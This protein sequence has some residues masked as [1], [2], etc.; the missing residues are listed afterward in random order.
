MPELVAGE[1]WKKLK[2][3]VETLIGSEKRRSRERKRMQAYHPSLMMSRRAHAVVEDWKPHP[4]DDLQS[5]RLVRVLDRL[6]EEE[7]RGHQ[8]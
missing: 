6:I 7:S 1:D 4:N 3:V 5:L 2:R 8:M